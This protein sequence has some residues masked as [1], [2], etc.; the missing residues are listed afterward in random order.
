MGEEVAR[1]DSPVQ[2]AMRRTVGRIAVAGVDIPAGRPMLL[3]LAAANRDPA[4]FSDPDTFDVARN[5]R[6]HLA[7]GGGAHL[8]LGAPIARLEVS[9]ALRELARRFPRLRLAG[10]ATWRPRLMFRGRAV[11]P[12]TLAP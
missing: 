3:G 2:F 12:V 5:D 9:V 10:D 1:F 8:C 11:V 7:F 6:R 4:V